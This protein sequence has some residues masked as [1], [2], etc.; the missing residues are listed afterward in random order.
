MVMDQEPLIS[1][2]KFKKAKIDFLK[3]PSDFSAQYRYG[4]AMIHSKNKKVVEEGCKLLK[5]LCSINT[6]SSEICM[7]YYHICYGSLRVNKYPDVRIYAEKL[8]AQYPT[9]RLTDKEAA[10]ENLIIQ[11]TQGLVILADEFSQNPQLSKLLDDKRKRGLKSILQKR[12]FHRKD[13]IE[14]HVRSHSLTSKRTFTEILPPNKI[15]SELTNAN[16]QSNS[17]NRTFILRH[18]SQDIT[19]IPNLQCNPSVILDTDSLP[20]KKRFT[21]P[22]T[23]PAADTEKPEP[24]RPYSFHMA[25]SSS[26]KSSTDMPDLNPEPCV[27]KGPEKN[28]DGEILELKETL[29]QLRAMY[30]NIYG[31]EQNKNNVNMEGNG[32]GLEREENT[33]PSSQN[34][35]STQTHEE[36]AKT[37]GQRLTAKT[38]PVNIELVDSESNDRVDNITSQNTYVIERAL[39]PL[40][41]LQLPNTHSEYITRNMS[42]PEFGLPAAKKPRLATLSKTMSINDPNIGNRPWVIIRRYGMRGGKKIRLPNTLEELIQVSGEKLGITAAC[43]REVTT[44]A[45]IEDIRAVETQ[46]VLWVMTEEDEL[47]FQ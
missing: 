31:F 20:T 41:A 26:H 47:S 35:N 23:L 17:S 18:A 37:V 2:D 1:A 24:R 28:S 5:E 21:A 45:E 27:T 44:E 10:N 29:T 42:K 22:P 32:K 33:N 36:G 16:S 40:P 11:K 12:N 30:D 39:E 6:T 38:Q 14:N 46:S 13:K 34:N 4:V 15:L 9:V 25:S 43:I 7:C 8:Y 3:S 19:S